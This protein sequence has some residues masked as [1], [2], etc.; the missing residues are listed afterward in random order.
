M[1][2]GNLEGDGNRGGM[3]ASKA[4]TFP[5][6][7]LLRLFQRPSLLIQSLLLTSWRNGLGVRQSPLF[8]RLIESNL[9]FLQQIQ[10]N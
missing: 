6:F 4:M 10:P 1:A 7:C 8:G 3:L 9:S 2:L 5:T